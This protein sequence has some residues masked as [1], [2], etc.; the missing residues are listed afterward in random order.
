MVVERKLQPIFR[1]KLM[2]V[3]QTTCPLLQ[4]GVLDDSLER[5]VDDQVP[6]VMS[7]LHDTVQLRLRN[8]KSKANSS[9]TIRLASVS[10]ALTPELGVYSALKR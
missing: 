10:S 7:N 2:F 4:A 6:A 3:L 8:K 5:V 1:C 9:C